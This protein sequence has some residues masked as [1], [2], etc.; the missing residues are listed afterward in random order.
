LKNLI[1]IGAGAYGREAFTLG[2]ESHGYGSDFTIKGYLDSNLK[3]LEKYQGYPLVLGTV[4]DYLI[5][6][7]DV[8]I[9]AIGG[10]K[11]KK[12]TVNQILEKQGVFI[13]LIHKSAYIGDFVKLGTGVFMGYD[14]VIS[15]D[16]QVE[17]YVLINSRALIGHDCKI[18]QFSLVG[19]SAFIAGNVNIGEEVTI[20]SKASIMKG[21]SIGYKATVGLG[22][23][24][25]KSVEENSTVFGNPAKRIF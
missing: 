3:A 21:I 2:K 12:R 11:Q 22:S 18:G 8:F 13:N 4:E 7:D 15:N 19:V 6:K 20:H 17:D 10:I 16:T 1:I 25:V 14:T 23:V 5:Q 24:A 9:C